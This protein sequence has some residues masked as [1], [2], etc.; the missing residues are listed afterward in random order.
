MVMGP[1][2]SPLDYELSKGGTALHLS[3][4]STGHRVGDTHNMDEIQ[5]LYAT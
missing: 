1:S 4:S 5:M 2:P 3:I